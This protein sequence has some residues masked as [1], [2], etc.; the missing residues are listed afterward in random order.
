[1]VISEK[2][3]GVVLSY[4]GQFVKIIVNLLYTPIML[5]LIGKNEYGLYQLVF[6][7]VSYLSLLSLGFSSSYMRFYAQFKAKEDEGEVAKLNGMF[8]IIFSVMSLVCIICGI[9]MIGNIRMIFGTGLSDSEYLTAQKLMF[10]LVVNL[11]VTFPNSV[12]NCI[13]TAH[14]KFLFQKTII[15]AQNLFSPFLSLPLLILGY[16]SVGMVLVTTILT[17]VVLLTNIF[18]C[19]KRLHIKF[20]FH[21]FEIG[22]LKEMWVFTFFIFLNQIIDQV[23]WSVDKFLLGR[24]AGTMA[25]AE[26]GVGSQINSMYIEFST[27]IS[28][29]F[30]PKVNRIVAESNDNEQLT[31]L[32]TKVGRIQFIVLGLILTGF[33]FFGRPFIT[34]WAGKE[35]RVSY[36]VALFLIIPVLIPLIQNLG[37][38]IQRAKNLHKARSIVYFFIAIANVFISIPLI[39][40]LGPVGAA[41][42]TA[43]SLFVGNI[44]F[45]N[46]YYHARVGMNMIYF[47]REIVKLIP[48]LI[49]P[50]VIGIIIMR[51]AN[52]TGFVKLGAFVIIYIAVYGCSIYFFGM[53]EEE[54]QLVIGPIR[55]ILRK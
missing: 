29:V 17:F 4:T 51:F 39:K 16:G 32:F 10:L 23:N 46:W 45:M 42:G 26:Y 50:F 55:K 40:L 11:A 54:K 31:L 52:I 19:K 30:V 22:L 25:V 41:F 12:F 36:V 21:G 48:A 34:M 2:K 13:V 14:E 27:S 35:Y 6:S 33:I 1:M 3:V 5:R 18:Y 15:L 20:I 7:V 9:I 38:E 53:N 24:F 43:V 8:L 47:W 49:A 28:N 37:I 44:I